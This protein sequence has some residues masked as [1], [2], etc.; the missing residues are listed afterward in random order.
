MEKFQDD[1]VFETVQQDF[2][3]INEIVLSAK[4]HRRNLML[5]VG[6]G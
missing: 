2:S 6:H 1:P 5:A 4:R 3:S